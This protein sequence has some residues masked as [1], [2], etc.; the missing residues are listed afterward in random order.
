MAHKQIIAFDGLLGQLR[1]FAR[2]VWKIQRIVVGRGG[3]EGRG[4]AR[5]PEVATDRI[6]VGR[7]GGC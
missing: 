7:G 5:V 1:Q 4:R 3:R 2:S 6:G